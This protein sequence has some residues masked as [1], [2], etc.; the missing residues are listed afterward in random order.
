VNERI[1][2]LLKPIINYSMSNGVNLFMTAQMGDK[3][4]GGVRVGEKIDTPR[5]L[6]YYIEIMAEM[7]KESNSHFFVDCMKVPPWAECGPFVSDLE[8]DLGLLTAFAS[9][10]LIQCGGNT[11]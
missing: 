5:W 6:D 3:Y 1:K 8:K 11:T 2:H 7:V 9:R 10:G 4:E